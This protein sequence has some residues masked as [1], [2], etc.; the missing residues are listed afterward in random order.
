MFSN[1]KKWATLT[2]RKE[3]F[4]RRNFSEKKFS[5]SPIREIK[6]AIRKNFS[7]EYLKKANLQK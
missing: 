2:L 1:S 5:L 7:A 4:A 3:I 6:L